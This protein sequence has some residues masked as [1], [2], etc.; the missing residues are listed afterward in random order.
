[1]ASL[2]YLRPETFSRILKQLKDQGLID[3]QKG[4]ISIL[5][6]EGLLKI[7]A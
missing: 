3:T 1:M 4:E 6:K 7:L 5:D 2:L